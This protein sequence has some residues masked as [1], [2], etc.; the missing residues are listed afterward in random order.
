MSKRE[1]TDAELKAVCKEAYVRVPDRMH[2][3][4]FDPLECARMVLDA[5]A[6]V[7][8][9]KQKCFDLQ[10]ELQCDRDV[11]ADYENRLA[12]LRDGDDIKVARIEGAIEALDWAQEQVYVDGSYAR[13]NIKNRI[14]VLELEKSSK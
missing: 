3:Y 2:V 6:E 10:E 13:H 7:A 9:L 1:W 4:S 11:M 8:A 5:R 12:R 14:T